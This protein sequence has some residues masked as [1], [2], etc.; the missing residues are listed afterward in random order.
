MHRAAVT[1]LALC[2]LAACSGEQGLNR[3]QSGLA[4]PDEFGVLPTRPLEMPETPGLPAPTPGGIN[5][6]DH[7]PNAEAI[8][9]L[10]GTPNAAF[11]GGIPASDVA[12]VTAAG[13]YGIDQAIRATLAQEDASFRNRQVRLNPFSSRSRYFQAYARF[14]LDAYAELSRFRNLGVAVPSAPPLE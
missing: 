14:A 9:A 6:A 1:C 2:L 12:L 7:T 13:R 8:A 5:R 3:F 10:G 4:G 11:A